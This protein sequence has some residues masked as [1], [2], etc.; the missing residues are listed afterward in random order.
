MEQQKYCQNCYYF[1]QHYYKS[2]NGKLAK[3]CDDGHCSNGN[4]AK[5]TSRKNILKCLSC[6]FWAPQEQQLAE[7]RESVIRVIFEMHKRLEDIAF[8][9]K[10]D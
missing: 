4:I 6:E 7:Q 8:I 10:D 3:I 1:C 9:L 2:T 5:L